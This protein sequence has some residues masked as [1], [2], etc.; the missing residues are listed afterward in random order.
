MLRRED[1]IGDIFSVLFPVGLLLICI[2]K[3]NFSSDDP[4]SKAYAVSVEEEH[5]P[6]PVVEFVPP[7]VS[8]AHLPTI[9]DD[10][11]GSVYLRYAGTDPGSDLDPDR[12]VASLMASKKWWKENHPEKRI[13]SISVVHDSYIRD[14]C[15]VGL[16]MAYEDK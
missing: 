4:M 5:F 7:V 6:A 13:I 1:R 14:T 3:A 8:N 11:A 2:W 9:H 15:V 10:G 12:V 16:L